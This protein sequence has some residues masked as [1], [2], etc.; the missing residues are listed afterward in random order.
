MTQ[1]ENNAAARILIQELAATRRAA[2]TFGA[3]V[4]RIKDRVATALAPKR[5]SSGA[6]HVAAPEVYEDL[7]YPDG[8]AHQS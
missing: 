2:E 5:A 6:D 3:A 7:Y 1:S 8:S 4:E